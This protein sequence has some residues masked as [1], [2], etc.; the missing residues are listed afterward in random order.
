MNNLLE[1]LCD[2]TDCRTVD[3]IVEQNIY[4]LNQFQRSHFTI[5]ANRAKRRIMIVNAEKKKSFINQLN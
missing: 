4:K 1:Q 3:R 5:F 2:A